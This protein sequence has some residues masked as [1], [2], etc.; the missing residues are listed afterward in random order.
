MKELRILFMATL[1]AAA[2]LV[3]QVAW[4]APGTNNCW[5][6]VSSQRASTL[7]DIG[8]HASDQA[9]P[10]L[11]LGNLAHDGIFFG[12]DTV[13]ELGAFLGSLDGIEATHCP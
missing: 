9:E 1:V 6:K 8:D 7:H 4:A 2:L 5:G 13:G 12:V 3:P 10:R 11:G